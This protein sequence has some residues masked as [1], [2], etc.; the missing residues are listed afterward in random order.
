MTNTSL[1]LR[2][3][4]PDNLIELVRIVSNVFQELE[5][6]IFLIGATVRDLVFANVYDAKITRATEDVD[7]GIA[8][9][10]WAEYEKL[11]KTLLEI[12]GFRDSEK[13]FQRVI[14]EFNGV[15]TLV[16]LVPYGGL[17]SPK[18]T[19]RFSDGDFEMSTIGFE[20]AAR[21]TWLLQ[22][23]PGLSVRIA[24]L[25]GLVLLKFVAY[26]DRPAL[27][28]RDLQDIWFIATHYLEAGNESRQ[29]NGDS[30]VVDEEYDARYV[31]A[32]LLGRDIGELLDEV[33]SE[34]VLKPLRERER[35]QDFIN[36]VSGEVLPDTDRE[37]IVR[38]R[39]RALRKGI[40][41]RVDIK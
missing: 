18:G 16:D 23:E 34:I 12:D 17:E 2:N 29:F 13:E 24:S 36:T 15:S 38:D 7:F 35:L 27:R 31:G 33:L 39:L 3:P 14:W 32:R 10:S 6:E 25:R 5:I 37:T 21:D 22:L 11:R 19:V 20:T 26:N 4:I 28:K 1:K 40:E 30:D 8:I 41:E 9:A